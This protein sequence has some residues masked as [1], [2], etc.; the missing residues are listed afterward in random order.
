MNAESLTL[1]ANAPLN[2]EHAAWMRD[3]LAEQ[4]PDLDVTVE[5]RDRTFYV[6]ALPA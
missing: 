2:R 6:E 1:A 3:E 5:V 4:F